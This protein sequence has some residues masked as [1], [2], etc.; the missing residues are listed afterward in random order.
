MVAEGLYLANELGLDRNIALDSDLAV[1]LLKE[2]K[3]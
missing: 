3:N 1:K 2:K